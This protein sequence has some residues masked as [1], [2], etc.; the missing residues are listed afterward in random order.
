MIK[1]DQISEKVPKNFKGDRKSGVKKPTQTKDDKIAS[2][3][4]AADSLD[5][6]DD[7]KYAEDADSGQKKSVFLK[8]KVEHGL[9]F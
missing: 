2:L 3:E 4:R 5:P 7:D 1:E 9:L 6:E 8:E